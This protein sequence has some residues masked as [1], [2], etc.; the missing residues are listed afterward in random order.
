LLLPF[1]LRPEKNHSAG[2]A[3]R[4]STDAVDL[5]L[6]LPSSQRRQAAESDLPKEQDLVLLPCHLSTAKVPILNWDDRTCVAT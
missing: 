5:F 6:P 4:A 2:G 1:H 3:E